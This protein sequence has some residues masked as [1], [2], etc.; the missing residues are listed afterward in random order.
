MIKDGKL[1]GKI[2]L[3]DAAILILVLALI[4]AGISKFKTF[5]KTVDASELGSITY[6]LEIYNVRDY[7]LS[8]FQSGDTVYD[9]GTNVNIGTIKNI[10]AVPAQTVKTLVDG[11]TKILE[12]EYKKDI[13]L[14]IET[15]GS[16][17][18]N[19]YYANKTIELKVDSEKE[20]ETLYAITF[21][22]I[23]SINYSEKEI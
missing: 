22:K 12:N 20:I 19:G 16:A 6:T 8:A 17:T 13:I 7:T 5:N 4:I 9:S 23:T 2:N 3:F 15:P 21:G 1:F 14:T 11:S 18:V 10:E